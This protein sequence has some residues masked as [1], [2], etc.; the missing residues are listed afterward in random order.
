MDSRRRSILFAAPAVALGLLASREAAAQ[1]KVTED[2]PT[3]KALGYKADGS[4]VDAAKFKTWAK[5]NTC[6][7]CNFYKSANANEGSCVAL[8]NKLVAAK[9]WC[10]AWIKKA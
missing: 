6:A 10:S 7:N 3:A 9:G 4:K 2:D 1:A 5:T 8:G